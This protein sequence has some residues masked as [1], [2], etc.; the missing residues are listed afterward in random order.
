MDLNI[1]DLGFGFLVK[2]RVYS[3]LEPSDNLQFGPNI[4][5]TVSNKGY[6]LIRSWSYVTNVVCL[7]MLFEVVA[8]LIVDWF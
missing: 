2:H 8:L 1:L 5:T 6:C 7:R 4:A 3:R